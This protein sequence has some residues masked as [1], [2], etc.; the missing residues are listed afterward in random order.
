MQ[1]PEDDRDRDS[2]GATVTG[3][4]HQMWGQGPL[5]PLARTAS[6]S[7]LSLSHLSSPKL[8]FFLYLCVKSECN[9]YELVLS[10]HCVEQTLTVWAGEPFSHGAIL[11]AQA[12]I[13]HLS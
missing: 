5:S 2:H 3:V 11:L 8:H 10:S 13:L 1:G 7:L 9:W 6:Y 12:Y 4:S